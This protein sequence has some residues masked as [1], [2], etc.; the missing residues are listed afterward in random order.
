MGRS[1]LGIVVTLWAGVVPAG[2]EESAIRILPLGDSI[3]EGSTVEES[4]RFWLG[5][6]LAAS[7]RRVDFVGS[8]SGARSGPVPGD[9]DADHEGHWG[10]RADEVLAQVPEWAAAARPDVVLVHLGHNDLFQGED[11]ASTRADLE[12]V[13]TALRRVNPSVTVLLGEIIPGEFPEL[14]ASPRLNREI[15]ELARRLDRPEARVIA[16][17]L[18][19]GFDPELDTSDGAHPN[20]RGARKMAAAW[21]EALESVLPLP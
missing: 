16:V 19:A 4:Y 13:V 2:G 9:F 15:V 6:D 1:A 10:W 5:R 14:E 17:D 7:G 21:L 12:G 3:T 11:A 20:V 8:L 18:V